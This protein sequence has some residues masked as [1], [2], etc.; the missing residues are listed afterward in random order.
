MT[1]DDLE[2]Q[3]RGFYGFFGDFGL[4]HTFQERIAPK[5]LDTDWDSLHMKLSA[6][7][8]R[9]RPLK[10]QHLR[11]TVAPSGVCKYIVPDVSCWD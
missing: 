2:H 9:I 3:N 10:R 6:L 11:E 1:L 7:N 5:S 4:R 8:T